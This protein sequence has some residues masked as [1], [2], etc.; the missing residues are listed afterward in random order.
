MIPSARE[1]F[2]AFLVAVIIVSTLIAGL[3]SI[4]GF[5]SESSLPDTDP[6]L[7]QIAYNDTTRYVADTVSRHI[8]SSTNTLTSYFKNDHKIVYFYASAAVYIS[9]SPLFT[10]G[11]TDYIPGSTMVTNLP[12]RSTR[13]FTN[14]YIKSAD[15]ATAV[16]FRIR[17]EGY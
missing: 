12:F 8:T 15:T 10:A 2:K 1:Q 7:Y 4:N 11:I 13:F 14:Y 17:L 16:T 3:L 9:T 6:T 5:G